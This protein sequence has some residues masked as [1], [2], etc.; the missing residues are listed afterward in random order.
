MVAL[1]ALVLAAPLMAVVWVLISLD[2]RGGGLYKQPRV[3]LDRRR[4]R[5]SDG[6]PEHRRR[7][8]AGGRIFTIYKFRTMR[9]DADGGGQC[10]ATKDDARVT[11]IGHVLRATRLDELPQLVNVLKGDMNVVGPR[12]EQ[13]EIFTALRS[14]I[15]GYAGRQTVLPGITGWAQVNAGYDSS[16]DDVRRKVALDL[17]YIERRSASADLSIMAR[18]MP[19][20]AFGREWGRERRGPAHGRRRVRVLSEWASTAGVSSNGDQSR[21]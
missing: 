8:D 10:W 5:A 14:E 6:G 17:D 3:G 21:S 1:V 4:R 12:P 9:V 15:A 18:T 7:H 19:V 20:I 2:S 11:R 13:P 16:I